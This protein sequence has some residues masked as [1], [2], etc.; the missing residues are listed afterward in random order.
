[1]GAPLFQEIES[2]DVVNSN[3]MRIKLAD[4]ILTSQIFGIVKSFRM[5]Q[6]SGG[7]EGG[8]HRGGGG[9][10]KENSLLG[11]W[12]R[13]FLLIVPLPTFTLQSIIILCYHKRSTFHTG[14]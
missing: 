8:G 9:K 13:M 11:C 4:I 2:Q 10:G 1:M 5:V 6:G 3:T 14:L 12:K 7:R